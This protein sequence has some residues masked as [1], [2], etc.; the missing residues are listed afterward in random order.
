MTAQKTEPIRRSRLVTLLAPLSAL[1]L[2]GVL[3]AGYWTVTGNP[4]SDPVATAQAAI[5]LPTVVAASMLAGTV[6][7]MSALARLGGRLVPVESHSVA[8]RPA[9][10][11]AVATRVAVGAAAGTPIGLACVAAALAAYGTG[12][13]MVSAAT[14]I[15]LGAVCGGALA[16]I[17]PKSAV[18]AGLYGSL[19]VLVIGFLRGAFA[20]ELISAIDSSHT[21]DSSLAA[22]SR[23]EFA[24]SLL[25]GAAAGLVAYRYLRRCSTRPRW[26]A[27][28]VAGGLPGLLLL[29]TETLVRSAGHRLLSASAGTSAIDAAALTYIT[30]GRVNHALVVFFAGAMLAII[31][32]GRSLDRPS[33][34]S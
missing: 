5:A 30:N 26:P 31:A 13:A 12:S 32:F 15:G 18:P 22:N 34:A 21:I 1:W 8:S 27:Y 25:S 7:G 19:A 24:V 9:V 20:G 6:A 17:R 33:P 3:W 28:L 2:V 11:R 16:A 10:L 14:A 29:V 4:G 23:I